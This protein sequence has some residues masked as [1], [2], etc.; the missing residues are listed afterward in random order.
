MEAKRRARKRDA[1]LKRERAADHR[2]GRQAF[3]KNRRIVRQNKIT[4]L[5]ELVT[6]PGGKNKFFDSSKPTRWFT[7]PERFYIIQYYKTKRGPQ[8]YL[9]KAYNVLSLRRAFL[10][11][12]DFIRP[13]YIQSTFSRQYGLVANGQLLLTTSTFEKYV[14]NTADTFLKSS[15]KFQP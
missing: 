14:N 6:P 2:R 1:R 15:E 12:R 8:V 13:V 3:L 9:F 11:F 7:R 4:F 10:K 5:R